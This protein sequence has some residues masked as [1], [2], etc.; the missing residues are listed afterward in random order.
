MNINK[1]LAEALAEAHRV[2]STH[3]YEHAYHSLKGAISSLEALTN[4]ED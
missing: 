3:G 4:K 2:R 1:A